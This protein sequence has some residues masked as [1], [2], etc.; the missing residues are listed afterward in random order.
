MEWIDAAT[1]AGARKRLACAE[2]GLTLRTLQ[3]WQEDDQLNI[4]ARTTAIK[5]PHNKLDEH[6]REAIVAV[7]NSAAYASLPP[8]QI[9]PRLAD[10][11]VYM[12]SESTFYRI[13]KSAGQDHRRGRAHPPRN[14]PTPTSHCA[15]EPN[16]V[17]S[18]DISVP[19]QAA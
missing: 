2:L 10:V 1:K 4:D 15:S 16:Q 13:L 7:C 9:V 11:Q 3:R 5:V 17:W 19:Q 6:E 18:W 14:I 12:A 8:S